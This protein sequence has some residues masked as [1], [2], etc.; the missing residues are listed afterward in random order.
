MISVLILTFNEENNIGECIE[1][2]SW[3]DDILV[4]DSGST[5]NTVSIAKC[6]GARILE[7]PFDNFANQRNYGLEHGELEYDWV[8]H[9]DADERVTSELK[10]ELISKAQK[11]RYKAYQIA[12][13]LMFLNRWIKHAGMYPTY[14]IRFGTKKDLKFKQVGHG[15]RGAVKEDE[16]GILEE[17][18]EHYVFS[19]GITD[20]IEKHN[21]YSTDEA[22]YAL[23]MY[24]KDLPS[25]TKLLNSTSQQ[26]RRFLKAIS[27]KLPFRPLWRFIYMFFLK[28]G[29]LDGRAGFY[30]CILLGIYEFFIDLKFEENKNK[31]RLLNIN[32]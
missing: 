32:E 8:L 5:D 11:G 2:V 9:L 7:R 13:K 24:Q 23:H 27:Y 18:L 14:Q 1:S 19:K 31:E 28:R 16:I 4:L 6:K 17:P 26:R 29:F 10:K 15:Q 22:Q 12:S 21:R 3:S 20:W 30:Y 25:I